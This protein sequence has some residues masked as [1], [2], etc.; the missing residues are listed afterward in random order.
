MHLYK[1]TSMVAV[2]TTAH[3]DAFSVFTLAHIHI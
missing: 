1:Y 3:I 2:P